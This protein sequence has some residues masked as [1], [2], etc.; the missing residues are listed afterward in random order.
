MEGVLVD[1]I[2]GNGV[3][4]AGIALLAIAALGAVLGFMAEEEAKGRRLF[5]AEWPLPESESG[6]IPP[7]QSRVPRA[8]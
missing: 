6:V 1:M 2:V 5:W 8:A 7:G 4:L 3:L